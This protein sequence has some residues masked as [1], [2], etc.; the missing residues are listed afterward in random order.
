MHCSELTLKEN[1]LPTT[2]CKEQNRRQMCPNCANKLFFYLI[3]NLQDETDE[4]LSL[5]MHNI[6]IQAIVSLV[7]R[8]Y[9]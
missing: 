2:E 7:N 1:N 4:Y 8:T 3:Y 9:R 5:R 6:L